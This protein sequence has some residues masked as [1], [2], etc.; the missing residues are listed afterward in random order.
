MQS[1]AHI[2]PEFQDLFALHVRCCVRRDEFLARGRRLAAEGKK[3]EAQHALKV[4]TKLQTA[5]EAVE[6]ALS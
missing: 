2:A 4:A 1:A 3:R 5:L 6:R